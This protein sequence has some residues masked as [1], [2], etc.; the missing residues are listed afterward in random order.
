MQKPEA[1]VQLFPA[2][3]L[4]ALVLAPN[5]SLLRLTRFLAFIFG[6]LLFCIATFAGSFLVLVCL[7]IP[8]L[9]IR[10]QGPVARSMVGTPL[11]AGGGTLRV[12]P[13]QVSELVGMGVLIRLT[14]IRLEACS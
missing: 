3:T 12:P 5:R 8:Q 13:R 10:A 6:R 14:P 2:R 7:V 11:A 4:L 9:P 1:R